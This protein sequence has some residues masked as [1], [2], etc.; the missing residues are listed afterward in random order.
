MARFPLRSP[1]L[2]R[3]GRSQTAIHRQRLEQPADLPL[4]LRALRETMQIDPQ[5]SVADDLLRRM[6]QFGPARAFHQVDV[7]RLALA[8]R[9]TEQ[10]MPMCNLR[11]ARRFVVPCFSNNHSPAPRNFRPVLSTIR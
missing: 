4:G 5:R 8:M 2:I 1:L 6:D 10:G 9:L 11:Q 7:E 3:H